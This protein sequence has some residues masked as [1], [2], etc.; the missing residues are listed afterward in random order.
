MSLKTL[1]VKDTECDFGCV[2]YVDPLLVYE[3]LRATT[4]KED[5]SEVQKQYFYS[6]CLYFIVCSHFNNF[7]VEFLLGILVFFFGHL[8]RLK[9][10][11][12]EDDHHVGEAHAEDRTPKASAATDNCLF[13]VKW[14]KSV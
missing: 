8:L 4:L 10:S 7:F 5:I 11:F 1:F 13:R 2:A 6:F 14:N 3:G 12:A 9:T